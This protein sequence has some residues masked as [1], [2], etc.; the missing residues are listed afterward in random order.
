MPVRHP[1]A[2]DL[3]SG[4]NGFILL[5]MPWRRLGWGLPLAVSLL[6][7]SGGCG[8][9]N[10]SADDGGVMVPDA[11]PL[12]AADVQASDGG[13]GGAEA[14]PD[15]CMTLGDVRSCMSANGAMGSQT[16]ISTS[17]GNVWGQCYSLTCEGATP[18]LH[19][20]CVPAGTFN[21]GGLMGETD[22][23]PARVVTI[24]RRFYIDQFEVSWGQFRTWWGMQPRPLP[25]DGATAYIGGNG[26][27]VVW[28]LGNGVPAP[29]TDLGSGCMAGLKN[30][31]DDYAMNCVAWETAL[32]YCMAEGKRLPTEAEWEY[33]ATGVGAGNDFPWG[34]MPM[35]DCTHA[36]FNQCT[37]PQTLGSDT[38]G[39]TQ[40][41][42]NAMSG[43]VAEWTLDTYPPLCTAHND[44]WPS[45]TTDPVQVMDTMQVYSVRGGSWNE[46]QS[47]LYSRAR[48][49]EQDS[50]YGTAGTVGFRC[51]RDER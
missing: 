23:S 17:S 26:D 2:F 16:C 24:R 7:P 22:T 37:W 5:D 49:Y 39:N 20:T 51:V 33:V 50:M 47:F 19:E 29:G 13:E 3:N 28:R 4:D 40:T 43:D 35:P 14:G 27:K 44:C 31:Q 12:D 32:A 1:L 25:A 34:N 42:I 6:L 11:S 41:N 38:A 18:M 15:L 36:I 45:S 10:V 30:A 8:A 48:D 21:M 9:P 46:G